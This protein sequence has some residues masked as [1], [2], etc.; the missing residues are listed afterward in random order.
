MYPTMDSTSHNINK[1]DTAQISYYSPSSAQ[2]MTHSQADFSTERH[3][4]QY[5]QLSD[6]NNSG[7][8]SYE[9]MEKPTPSGPMFT[10]GGGHQISPND[11][12][13]P[14]RWGA[15]KKLYASLAAT[16]LVFA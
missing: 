3:D 9:S 15:L 7:E 4:V 1:T 11:P 10:G 6:M 14:M 13:N 5:M 8:N 12:N 2:S 16:F